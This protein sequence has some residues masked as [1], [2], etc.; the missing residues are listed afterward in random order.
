MARLRAEGLTHA[1]IGR[2]VGLSRQAVSLVLRALGHCGPLAVACRECAS[3]IM[4]RPPG[5]RPPLPVLCLACLG[6]HPEAP[7]ADRLRAFRH[8]AGLTQ[9]QVAE[10][11]G[12]PKAT[13]GCYEQGRSEP[14]WPEVVALL[15]AL[16]PGLLTLGLEMPPGPD[17]GR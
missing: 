10:R 1:E 9:R 2:R 5:S 15:R 8:A 16:G 4:Q 17:E 3:V 7:F 14:G 13:V 6:R 11:A 12:L